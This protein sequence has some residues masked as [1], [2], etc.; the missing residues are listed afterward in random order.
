[1]GTVHTLAMDIQLLNVSSFLYNSMTR[2]QSCKQY[3]PTIARSSID[4]RCKRKISAG[5]TSSFTMT[6]LVAVLI[7]VRASSSKLHSIQMMFLSTATT[8]SFSETV[9]PV[10]SRSI[11]ER[12]SLTS[13]IAPPTSRVRTESFSS[14]STRFS[15]PDMKCFVTSSSL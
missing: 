2:S 1:M 14:Y 6:H 9:S 5:L 8:T 15:F 12:P 4:P 10:S 7:S 13:C 3:A 11:I